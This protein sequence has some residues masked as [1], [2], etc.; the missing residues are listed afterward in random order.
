MT[1]K[2]SFV[3][4]IREDLKQRVW[5]TALLA[6][7]F[8][9]A[10]PAMT[11]L[12]IDSIKNSGMPYAQIR[13]GVKEWI[14]IY[15][16]FGNYFLM[17]LSAG[18]AVLLGVTEFSYLH[19]REKL[20]LYHSLPVRRKKWFLTRYLAGLLSFLTVFAICQILC[21]VIAA[22][23][24]FLTGAGLKEMAGT[25]LVRIV[26][27]LFLYHITIF[28]MHFTGK[29]ALAVMGV[30]ILCTYGPAV[31]ILLFS[32]VE[33]GFYTAILEGMSTRMIMMTSPVGILI[34][35]ESALDGNLSYLTEAL[36]AVVGIAGTFLLNLW[37]CEHRHTE[38]AGRA[39]AFPAL[40]RILQFLLVLPASLM[41]GLGTY[42]ITGTAR[43]GWIFAGFLFGVIVL[44][45][46]ME[47]I[48]YKD[49]KMLLR[50][51]IS[52]GVTACAGF[53]LLGVFLYDFAGYNAYLPKKEEIQA[54]SVYKSD[55]LLGMESEQIEVELEGQEGMGHRYEYSKSRMEHM[56]T[57][58][59]DIL[60]ELAKEGIANGSGNENSGDNMIIK[61]ILK[62]GK[63][64]YRR[65]S[66]DREVYEKAEDQLY[67][68][69]WYREMCFPILAGDTKEW[70]D[71]LESFSFYNSNIGV[72]LSKVG[73]DA[74][75]TFK[76][77]RERFAELSAE[78]I[79]NVR[80]WDEEGH[81]LYGD[82]NLL[83]RR[84]DGFRCNMMGY[85]IN[86][87]FGELWEELI[88]Q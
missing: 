14:Q 1:S 32:L 47:F 42:G 36:M 66:I 73:K 40:E 26:V 60:Y 48:Y 50:H 45:G 88:N 83:I 15:L 67:E 77:Y 57:E 19:S 69:E 24:G 33:L 87:Q 35:L 9:L 44:S 63:E 20:D 64:V 17:M 52:L 81:S 8:F 41:I 39:L 76:I 11:M 27:F 61:Y 28:A 22:S 21:V 79:R 49:L 71:R 68:Q 51:K 55:S 82:I 59:F 72:E 29:T 38:G 31:V 16:G 12:S 56:Q 3:K 23:G 86:D 25:A 75:K 46:L 18:A 10:Y 53:L 43:Y 34:L 13:D 70:Q 78:E 30:L 4:L 58:D 54:M 6:V 84:D 85:L 74:K 7:V 5:T 37:M 62:N 80:A 2:I 65:Y